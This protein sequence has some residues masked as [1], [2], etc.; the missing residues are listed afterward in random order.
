MSDTFGTL[1]L[2]GG[3]CGPEAVSEGDRARGRSSHD[4]STGRI[5][6]RTRQHEHSYDTGPNVAIGV[7]QTGNCSLPWAQNN[8]F[9]IAHCAGG[10]VGS[11]AVC[12]EQSRAHRTWHV[13]WN[14]SPRGRG[15]LVPLPTPPSR[16]GPGLATPRAH[17]VRRANVSG[18]QSLP[19]RGRPSA[20]ERR[21]GPGSSLIPRLLGRGVR[22]WGSD[23]G[24]HRSEE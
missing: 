2:R 13:R 10:G 6:S 7:I 3:P 16:L 21:S 9:P 15:C 23:I 5:R 19:R 24:R 22:M 20:R 4:R 18:R 8:D 17:S 1:V 12:S 11:A 14:R